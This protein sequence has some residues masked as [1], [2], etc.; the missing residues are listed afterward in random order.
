MSL[1]KLV[2]KKR[3]DKRLRAGHLWI[4]SNEIDT[5]K[6]PLKDFDPGQCVN[7]YSDNNKY[8]ATAYINPNT[9]ITARV[10]SHKIDTGLDQAWFENQFSTCLSLR[11]KIYQ[12]P[13]YRFCFS[14][15]DYVP[16]LIIDR[17]DK[18]WVLQINTAGMALKQNLIIDALKS[19]ADV[20]QIILR[21]DSAARKL[22]LLE[23]E[24][25]I[26][27]EKPIEPIVIKE[28]NSSYLI[29][30]IKGQKTGWFYDQRV[31]RSNMFKWVR[32]KTVLDVFSYTGSWSISAANAGAK[33]V[34]AIDASE[35]ALSF[36]NENAEINKVQDKIKTLCADAFNALQKLVDEKQQ[37]DVIFVDPPA[38]IK[39]KKD[40]KQ[41]QQAYLRINKLAMKLVKPGGIL[42]SSS[43]SYHMKQAEL[44]NTLL[45]AS[46]Q[47]NRRLQLIEIGQQ[48]PDHP[49]HPAITET[50][51]LKC[52]T[53]RVM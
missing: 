16:G 4:F 3:E 36:V 40:L 50:A 23:M 18:T 8:I 14:E 12:E 37:Y 47:L 2:L 11:E 28:N 44:Q 26:I 17:Y 34:I 53:C 24:T 43:C 48:G 7:V 49:I 10:Y 9:L 33:S 30:P 13:Y 27:P 25:S 31:N 21:N 45:M 52:I 29:D 46:R 15:G 32:D 6:T 38:F 5:K 19:I 1:K 20:Q 42:I 41:G 51:Y 39:R 35:S 22:E